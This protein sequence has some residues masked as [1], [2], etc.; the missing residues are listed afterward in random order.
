MS[1][2]YMGYF[3]DILRPNVECSRYSI[4]MD[5]KY[6]HKKKKIYFKKIL[7]MKSKVG[8][9]KII[10]KGEDAFGERNVFIKTFTKT[11]QI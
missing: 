6:A 5:N 4:L 3:E 2:N 11:Y 10:Y 9:R 1:K 8:P 7:G